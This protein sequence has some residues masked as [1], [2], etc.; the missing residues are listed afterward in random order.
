M[1]ANEHEK[2]RL[3]PAPRHERRQHG[4]K[5]NKPY[6]LRRRSRMR[7]KRGKGKREANPP[8]RR[9]RGGG[10]GRG[11]DGFQVQAKEIDHPLSKKK[12]VGGGLIKGF[13][14]NQQR[15]P[16][17]A[18]LF[19]GPR[20]AGGSGAVYSREKGPRPGGGGGDSS[21]AEDMIRSGFRR[22]GRTL[23][24]YKGSCSG[25]GGAGKKE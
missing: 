15:S 18:P 6:L 16:H 10:A 12:N 21:L 8:A 11:G 17:E 1:T 13:L 9:R 5:G 14:R 7:R 23:G 3:V 24:S 22:R 4:S 25:R 2:P 20:W 19:G